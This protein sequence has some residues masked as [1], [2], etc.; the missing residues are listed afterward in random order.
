MAEVDVPAKV[1][2]SFVNKI[3]YPVPELPVGPVLPVSLTG[4]VT[5]LCGEIGV[6]SVYVTITFVHIKISLLQTGGIV[7]QSESSIS[8]VTSSEVSTI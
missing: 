7:V 6:S 4:P 2:D 1:W 5:D 3:V 8:G